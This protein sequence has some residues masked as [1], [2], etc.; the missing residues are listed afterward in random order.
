[1]QPQ[2][3][4]E[5][6]L[7]LT[8][9][10]LS[11]FA[12]R[13][14]LPQPILT[15]RQENDN[16]LPANLYVPLATIINND[17]A[18]QERAAA[19]GKPLDARPSDDLRTV[20]YTQDPIMQELL[21]PFRQ[22]RIQQQQNPLSD[23]EQQG[24]QRGQIPASITGYLND[25]AG[26]IPAHALKPV[27][28]AVVD[29]T[30]ARKGEM[31]PQFELLYT[32]SIELPGLVDEPIRQGLKD[33]GLLPM[34][35]Q[36]WRVDM[37]SERSRSDATQ[38]GIA[39][40]I[41]TTEMSLALPALAR[42]LRQ[43]LEGDNYLSNEEIS[44]AIFNENTTRQQMHQL[45]EKLDTTRQPEVQQ[46]V[47]DYLMELKETTQQF[48]AVV[49]HGPST[50]IDMVSLMNVVRNHQS[51]ETPLTL[52]P[53]GEA[54]KNID[55]LERLKKAF[56]STE[57]VQDQKRSI[58]TP[59]DQDAKE[60]TIKPANVAFDSV[61]SPALPGRSVAEG[62][63]SLPMPGE[64]GPNPAPAK[65]VAD[66]GESSWGL[67]TKIL[68][69]KLTEGGMVSNFLN[70]YKI[71]QDLMDKLFKGENFGFKRKPTDE[72]TT[73]DGSSKAN[74][75]SLEELIRE[76]ERRTR[77]AGIN[78]ADVQKVTANQPIDPKPTASPNSRSQQVDSER[79]GPPVS[80]DTTTRQ[81]GQT[82][83]PEAGPKSM[84]SRIMDHFLDKLAIKLLDRLESRQQTRPSETSTTTAV[85]NSPAR[86]LATDVLKSTA[87]HQPTVSAATA[88]SQASDKQATTQPIV[89]E[90]FR[91]QAAYVNQEK[92]YS[93]EQ[94]K[95]QMD[96]LGISE[97]S[98]DPLNKALLLDGYATH[99]NVSF[100]IKD[101]NGIVAPAQG[102]LLL[103]EI[104]GKGPQVHI[105]P[106]QLKTSLSVPKGLNL[107][108]EDIMRLQRT[109]MANRPVEYT[110]AQTATKREVL[111][112]YDPVAKLLRTIDKE[113]IKVPAEVKGQP[114]TTQQQELLRDG[115]QIKLTGL[116]DENKKPYA[117]TLQFSAVEGQF[118]L[119]RIGKKQRETIPQNI[120]Q[121]PLQPQPASGDKPNQGFVIYLKSLTPENNQKW[122]NTTL[123]VKTGDGLEQRKKVKELT[124]SDSIA[125]KKDGVSKAYLPLTMKPQDNTLLSPSEQAR[126]LTKLERNPPI[127]GIRLQEAKPHEL[128]KAKARFQPQTQTDTSVVS[129]N[130]ATRIT[131]NQTGNLEQKPAGNAR[132]NSDSTNEKKGP[133][134]A[135]KS[136]APADRPKQPTVRRHS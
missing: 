48:P 49:H 26:E 57:P 104:P 58:N 134:N 135:V 75:L 6:A 43:Y 52:P 81:Y 107:Y 102:K 71:V 64:K 108:T 38:L 88:H 31:Y 95:P 96:K 72:P 37:A 9:A 97:K 51:G 129:K 85:T 132:Q 3:V 133:T 65:R 13:G 66:E 33:Q 91:Q 100:T 4:T 117:A 41:Q 106:P 119:D 103:I 29:T 70:N 20:L 7:D 53:P 36:S 23:A 45:V 125:V 60:T 89:P 112:G 59:T 27:S 136:A 122:L 131:Q 73:P 124:Y 113:S 118:R 76:L 24:L 42:Q 123:D 44:R 116:L 98:I 92:R 83:A 55:L 8:V 87:A 84:V 77:P 54:V 11:A 21:E 80:V 78:Q 46:R 128:E 68:Q 14:Q 114:L 32:R 5:P 99:P 34:D 35:A 120:K 115:K 28:E 109:G 12:Q 62:D 90:T 22:Q 17:M 82:T 94:I 101:R 74:Q 40:G 10:E 56:D 19:V 105:E 30:V 50:P 110:D 25:Y 61:K 47:T 2:P 69:L 79:P 67:L 63:A 93:W 86:V 15:Y 121:G 18:A 1:M 111:V 130:G 39:E 127:G 16:R 126:L